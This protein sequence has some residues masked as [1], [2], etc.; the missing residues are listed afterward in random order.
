MKSASC[1][2]I[3]LGVLLLQ[4]LLVD[5]ARCG[6]PVDF[7]A[8]PGFLKLP[9]GWTLGQCSAVA[10][11]SRGEIY[12]FHRGPHPIICFDSQGNYLRSWGDDVIDTA[13]GLRIDQDDNVWTTDIGNHRVYKFAPGG[14]LLMALGTGKAGARSDQFNKP[15]DVAFGP[16]GEFYVSDGYGNTRVLKF[17]PSGALITFW[18]RPGTGR[19][20]FNLPHSIVVDRQGRI[21]VGDR[22][23]NRIQIFDETGKFLDE[24]KGFAPFGLALDKDG[25]LFVADGR[26]NKILRL[27]E[28]GQLAQSWGQ[29]GTAPGEFELP[30][31]LTLDAAGN[32]LVAE[33]NGKRLQ[34]LRRK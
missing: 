24:W 30:H 16:Q 19:G 9:A 13:H 28:S 29:K 8:V 6:P 31:M 10:V 25:Q 26:A 27:N 3:L 33:V 34:M 20:E 14:K 1:P 2:L 5:A 22:E 11:N 7:V 12:L 17:S 4:C 23:N 21:L 32:L 15:T 18:G